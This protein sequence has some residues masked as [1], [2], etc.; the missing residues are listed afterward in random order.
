MFHKQ[1]QA[2]LKAE[3]HEEKV[4]GAAPKDDIMQ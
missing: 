3:K 2:E 1:F 4:S